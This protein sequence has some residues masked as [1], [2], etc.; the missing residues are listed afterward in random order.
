MAVERGF[1]GMGIRRHGILC[2]PSPV[3]IWRQMR[4]LSQPVFVGWRWCC[5]QIGGRRRRRLLVS[6]GP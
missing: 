2:G 3:Q 4:Q 6:R 1:D 5:L